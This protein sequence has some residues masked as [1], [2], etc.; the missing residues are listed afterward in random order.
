ML[1]GAARTV[2][3]KAGAMALAGFREASRLIFVDELTGLYNRRFMRQYLRERLTELTRAGTPLAVIML[4]VDGFKQVND[5]YGHL[6]GDEVL[7]TLAQRVR[8]ALPPSAYA[9]RFAGDEFFVFLE[10]VDGSGGLRVAEEIRTLVS[11]TPFITAKAP[12]GISLRVSLGV[13][14]FPEDA[15]APSE[16]IDE[17][18]QALYRSKRAGKDRVSR[19]GG[20]R[21]PPEVEVFKRFPCPQ[22]I[23]REAELA[24]LEG[25]LT[26]GGHNR[27]LLV[28]ASRGLG[29]TR[30]LLEL[31]R[32]ARSAGHRCLFARCLEPERGIP[33]STLRPV[34]IS[35][36]E[37]E[38]ER[39]E[40]ARSRV[41]PAALAELATLLPDLAPDG[42]QTKSPPEARR[43][44]LFHGVSDLLCLL[45]S[46]A[47]LVLCLDDLQFVDE[48]SLEVLVRLLER[49]EGRVIVY[50]AA[51]SEALERPA[52]PPLPLV[53]ARGGL[54]RAPGFHGVGLAALTAPEVGRMVTAILERH[55]AS[56]DFLR[57][58]YEAS[59]G[60]PLFVEETLKMLINRGALRPADGVW[61]LDAVE[62]GAVPASLEAVIRAGLDMLDHELHQMIAKAAVVGPHVDL[63]LLAGVLGKDPGETLHLV[64]KGTKH[65]VFE[66]PGVMTD[67]EEVRFLS[68][69]FQQIV[70][71]GLD[72][73]D[74]RRTHRT[75]G[76][77]AERLAGEQI[78]AVLGPLAYHFERSDD[79]EKGQLYRRRAEARSVELF[80]AA[81]IAG[82]FSLKVGDDA[83]GPPL[84]A[85]TWPLA[86]RVL[87]AL[88]VAVKN[89]RVYPAGG[90]LVQ[91]GV[92]AASAALEHLL[93]RVE[94]VALGEEGKVL[95]VNG[96]PVEQKGLLPTA[97]DLLR[98]F[99]DHGI[100]RCTFERGVAHADV[101]GVLR[102]LSGPAQSARQD[103]GDWDR[104][105]Q[106]EGIT[107]VRIFP[108]IYLAAGAGSAAWRRE[109][110]E[111][112]L[113]DPTLHLVRDVLRSLAAG[114]DNIRLY[115][116]ESQ[117]ITS[118]FDQL[119]RHVQALF[120][121]I[122]TLTVALTEGNLV[123]NAVRPSPRVFGVTIEVLQKLMDDSGLTS[124]T[125]RR[126][127]TRE[128]L[129][130]F[131]TRLAQPPE[132]A[133]GDPAFW[134]GL[135]AQSGISTIE[136]GTR[137]YAAAGRL[138]AEPDA[139]APASAAAVPGVP[140]A[141][142]SEAELA[143]EQA[144]RWLAE[145][146][147][148]FLGRG[149][150]AQIPPVLE[151]L[152]RM[153]REEVAARLV[154][155]TASGL[156][157][158]DGGLRAGAAAGLG[159]VLGRVDDDT[160]AWL[161]PLIVGPLAAVTAR[162]RDVEA[163]HAQASLATA[164]LG[165]LLR[166]GDLEQGAQLTAAL[167]SAVPNA[168][169]RARFGD[170]VRAV[171]DAL[172]STE[173]FAPVLAGLKDADPGRRSRARALLA[174]FGPA[175]LPWLGRLLH[176]TADAGVARAVAE[177]LAAQG[178][179]G[180]RTVTRGLDRE[181]SVTRLTRVVS[182]LDVLAP[183]LGADF[184]FL[185]GHPEVQVRGELVRTLA[186]APREHALRFVG[187]ALV[188]RRPEIRL[189]ALECVRALAAVELLDAVVRLLQA[190]PGPQVLRAACASLGRLKDPRAVEALVALADRRPRYFGL[191]RGLPESVRAA[192]V[193][194]LGELAMPE[195]KE[196][197][198]RALRDRS[199]TVRS[200]AR[201]ALLRL[202]RGASAP[203]PLT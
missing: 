19:A 173:S 62:P 202:P 129:R 127:V 89:M 140:V 23:G 192:A 166:A 5:T 2:P 95:R 66:D 118:T 96:Q 59:R 49:P 25:V 165:R 164:V 126:G 131:L 197:L 82:E 33:Y 61:D 68:Q 69:C 106:A 135:L 32:R 47:P 99:A 121:R 53:R 88:A 203:A 133:S 8:D 172:A 177:L 195:A 74:R 156:P 190:A 115:P 138:A 136:V 185:V 168:P 101:A 44:L 103:V 171:V 119:E 70:Y 20:W 116:A 38:P 13:A 194:A 16:L 75:V 112:L 67:E 43:R 122:P 98:I 17:V 93:G 58:L 63:T 104:A 91:E 57:Q 86:D 201:L 109:H 31:M 186:R 11:R 110:A 113:D 94:T 184:L 27:L 191:V 81:E 79:V 154:E 146:L 114:V 123:V 198:E 24:A 48:A 36:L 176:E 50:A 52:D 117:L 60:V 147:P 73:A 83:G 162:E 137:A 45:S 42:A 124:L 21:L 12:A 134:Q 105:L 37:R 90:R 132:N 163:F 34:L 56:P 78:D 187:Q 179:V 142:L 76:E 153:G 71:D 55:T 84:D 4:D 77:V 120:A 159:L 161:L 40:A 182:L 189:G 28:E 175:A 188:H 10:G 180:A 3:E 26:E 128:Q 51:Q 80:S 169:D 170:A 111:A 160:A 144:S 46:D 149:V 107:H 9:V 1:S 155:R 97:Q 41:E 200:A 196:G 151:A 199:R 183:T 152:R 92:A 30:L 72:P 125:V 158:A 130:A 35:C 64:D 18:D 6:D 150:Q 148:V 167:G 22:L 15:P 174:G 145:P 178:E 157:E 108:I 100:R 181:E 139:S 14:A 141:Q 7:K 29:K 193:R 85:E 54:R 39:R 65:R 143:L 102:L 87:R